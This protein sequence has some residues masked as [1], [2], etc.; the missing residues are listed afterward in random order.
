MRQRRWLELLSEYG[1]EIT[2]IKRTI[3]RVAD[4]LS[5]RPCIFLVIPHK[6]NLR[7]N[8]L[9]LHIDDDW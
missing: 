6:T 2:S 4:A 3:N 5:Q 1:F 7:E 8:I 9:A